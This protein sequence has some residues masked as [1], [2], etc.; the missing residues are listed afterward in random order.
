[1]VV[2]NEAEESIIPPFA[3]ASITNIFFFMVASRTFPGWAANIGGMWGILRDISYGIT[4]AV[5]IDSI[6]AGRH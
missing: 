4:A 2:T 3:Y 1:M 6:A 5:P